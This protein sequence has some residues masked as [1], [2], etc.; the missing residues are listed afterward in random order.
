[1]NADMLLFVQLTCFI[2]TSMLAFFLLIGPT[3]VERRNRNY[4][5]SRWMLFAAMI[6]FSVHY[7]MQMCFGFRAAGEDIGA[8]VNIVFYAPV[9]F[10]T[11][12][13]QLNL[14][15]G[16]RRQ[17]RY[18]LLVTLGYALML[19]ILGLGRWRQGD[20]H[21]GT[22]LY[23]VD[24]LYLLL[25][26]TAVLLPAKEMRQIYRRVI[27]ETG[28][29]AET[30]LR[31]M[32]MGSIVMFVFALFTQMFL[33][34]THI[35]CIIG[36]ITLVSF[37]YFVVSFVA[38]GYNIGQVADIIDDEEAALPT[39]ESKGAPF[40]GDLSSSDDAHCLA[41]ELVESIDRAIARWKVEGG[42]RDSNASIVSLARHIGVERRTLTDYLHMQ[43]GCTFRIW[44][45]NLR[46][47]EA[48]CLLLEHEEYSNEVIAFECGFSSASQLYR[49]FKAATG[50]T[51]REWYEKQRRLRGDAHVQRG[52]KA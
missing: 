52:M 42:M 51:P 17:R 16:G 19:S 50:S 30:Y 47:E 46:M 14:M 10:L 9:G 2:I 37:A 35:L 23:V 24:V 26:I 22:E 43:Y 36:P 49:V 27:E 13:S 29:P 34:N 18:W 21:L 3:F 4:E 44:L 38:L 48:K 39:G 15:H 7:L 33:F 31:C 1:M 45:S 6:I 12:Y 5:Q 41:P 25:I 32:K 20:W 11:S 40:H 8:L 28:N